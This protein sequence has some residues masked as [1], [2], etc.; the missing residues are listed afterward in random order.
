MNQPLTYVINGNTVVIRQNE[1]TAPVTQEAAAPVTITGVVTDEKGEPLPGVS[2][3]LKGTGN[4]VVSG[5]NGQY[6][7]RVDDDNAVL[8][9]SFV[10]FT[11]QEVAVGGQTQ[12]NVTLKAQPAAIDEVVVVGYGTVKKRDLTGAVGQ[13]KAVD[14]MRGGPISLSQGLQGKLAGVQVNQNDGAPGAGVSIQIRGANSYG[15]NTQPLYVMDGIP[16]DAASTPTNDATSGNNQTFNPLALINPS[17]IESIEI[18]KDASATAIYG[19]RGANGVVLITT[20]KGKA[21]ATK[22]QF[23]TNTSVSQLG[24]NVKVLGAYDYANYVNEGY[25]NGVL[26]ND[27]NFYQLPYPGQWSYPFANNQFQYDQGV[28]QPSPEDFL[29]PGVRTDTYGNSTNVQSS[30]WMD[31]ITRKAISQEYNL[32]VSGGSE[33]GFY[34]VSGNYAK[35]EGIIR[36]S[37]FERYSLRANVGQKI[38]NWM[39]IGL[40]TTFGRTSSNFAK[41]NS[42]DYG[43]IRSAMIFPTTF[44]PQTDIT[45]ISNQLGWL[46]A[47]PY[48]Y[49]MTAK[50]NLA[51]ISS[52]SSAYAEVKFTSWLKFRQN[53]GLNYSAN[54]RGTYYNSLTGEGQAPTINGRAGQSDD[55]YSN[56]VTESLLTFNKTLGK[57]H[58]LN[59][60]VGFTHENANYASKS[61]SATNFPDDLTGEYDMGKA[62]NPGRLV[63][64]RGANELMSVLARANYSLLDRYLFTVSFRRDGSSKFATSNKFANFL[65]GAFAWRASE[66]KF[67]KDLNLFSDLKLRASAGRTG[68][69]A[70][71]QY[72]TLPQLASANY[73]LGG[74]LQSG[75]AES[76][77]N[78]PANP[79]LKWETTTQYDFGVDMAFLDN[80]ISLTVD[81]YNKKTTDLLQS[82]KTPLSTG[83]QQMTIN[84]GWVKND[85]LEITAKVI[86]LAHGP[87]KWNIDGNI[88]FNRNTIGGLDNDQFAS[89]LW[90][91]ADYVFIQRNGM[92]IG[93]IYGYVEDGFYDNEA[94]VRANPVYA[95]A[96]AAIIKQK[97]GEVKYLNLDNDPNITDADRTIIGNTNP[98][99]IAGLTNT[100]S[101]KNFNLSFFLQGVYGNDIFNGNLTD[102]TLNSIGNIPAFAYEGR[103]TPQTTAIATWPKVNNGYTREWLISNRYIQDGSYLRLKSL[104]FGYDFLKPFKGIESIGVS[105]TGTNLLTFTKYNWFDPDVNSFGG[106]ASRRGVDIHAYPNSQTFSLSARVSF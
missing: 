53:L 89:R 100:F 36:N 13:I 20:K 14:L 7:I 23:S 81:Y 97:I 59:A 54:N 21:G 24:K 63:S 78:G 77:Y 8:V 19:S 82:I 60:V 15:T 93:A 106:D 58:S 27:Y 51:A 67:I 37:N 32:S 31:L 17:D 72:A 28:Y 69:Q 74:S 56:I 105:L 80:R 85:G 33:R 52:F 10:G 86:A 49:V 30:N 61:M 39:E 44:E 101:Y 75:M 2:I 3:R 55:W 40:N 70:I 96:S 94:E 9:F 68:N 87:L 83:F 25:N 92:P 103:W 6:S 46:S 48:L 76:T 73:P 45:Q 79:N 71:A 5:T 66:E 12:I 95:N 57:I 38:G 42:F 65:S 98:D 50:D 16:F 64:G 18:L 43:I 99:F 104:S 4:G 88:S 1:P 84:R 26:Y 22:V 90:N 102:V 62:L 91:A 35:Q 47:N 41:T 34:S 11:P 29:S